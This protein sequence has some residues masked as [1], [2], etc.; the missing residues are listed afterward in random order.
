MD[1]T[2]KV[3]GQLGVAALVA[4]LTVLIIMLGGGVAQAAGSV[5]T[6]GYP[7]PPGAPDDSS[8][9][10]PA[11][12]AIMADA[13]S[14]GVGTFS[15]ASVATS[16]AGTSVAA[17][18]AAALSAADLAWTGVS[19]AAGGAIAVGM[20]KVAAGEFYAP[21]GSTSLVQTPGLP[22]GF[23][24][25]TSTGPFGWQQAY[26]SISN[27]L[28]VYGG[29]GGANVSA[30]GVMTLA[31]TVDS[32]SDYIQGST[33][34]DAY[35]YC[36]PVGGGALVQAGNVGE[37]GIGL[38]NRRWASN[39]VT[40]VNLS[41]VVDCPAG[42]GFDH[43]EFWGNVRR[44]TSP[45][46][47]VTV[48]IPWYP[49]GHVDWHPA[50]PDGL[51]GTLVTTADC[52]SAAGTR[53]FSTSVAAAGVGDGAPLEWPGVSCNAGETLGHFAV[54]WVTPSGTQSVYSYTAPGWVVTMPVEYPGCESGGCQ[55]ELWKVFSGSPSLYCGVAA[56]GCPEWV[57]DSAKASDYQCRFG[58]YDA[59][60]GL[61]YGM[62][63]DPGKVSPN[64]TVKVDPVTGVVTG[65]T[66]P[67]IS[68]DP[69][70]YVDTPVVTDPVPQPDPVPPVPGPVDTPDPVPSSDSTQCF[71]HGWGVFNPSEWVL[72]PVKCAFAWAF[73]P[74]PG[75]IQTI[76]SSGIA[77]VS[78]DPLLGAV[79]QVGVSL[80]SLP[81]V[82]AGGCTSEGVVFDTTGVP[83]LGDFRAVI[84]CDPATV[85]PQWTIA[86]HLMELSMS[87]GTLLGVFYI[88]RPYFVS[89]ASD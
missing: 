87:V 33:A 12:W 55:V 2:T 3:L 7:C 57:S 13:I 29:Y 50:Q 60:L 8:L 22:E 80:R 52:V 78:A 64:T 48:V 17:G 39:Y 26:F 28:I 63:R 54:D 62:F 42:T 49:P 84:P 21:K 79:L 76:T 72:Q 18:G 40:T 82:V 37:G 31:S 70:A 20:T 45:S 81:T 68:T 25:P 16:A 77:A 85:I 5:R 43:L 38:G 69:V 46:S 30:V 41:G 19:A 24:A 34:A 6:M 1:R 75:V 4:G 65:T 67:I 74:R 86:Y 32:G 44:D 58:G 83:A 51:T 61:C 47:S 56:V 59:P 35:V 89:K 23:G 10:S 11:G 27:D 66:D 14:E 71:P 15:S 73:V 9:C 36:Q 88:V 53:S